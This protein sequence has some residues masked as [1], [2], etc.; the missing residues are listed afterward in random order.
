M[1]GLQKLKIYDA[2]AKQ[3]KVLF[4]AQFN[5]T[6]LDFTKNIT[7]NSSKAAGGDIQYLSF[8]QGDGM[9]FSC[10]LFLDTTSDP[11]KNI[12]TE[13]VVDLK[14]LAT[15]N[16]DKHRPPQLYIVWGRTLMKCVLTS[17]KYNFT[18]FNKAGLAIRGIAD[19]SFKQV[20][21]CGK[22]VSNGEQQ[23]PDHTKVR[24]L[25]E[26]DSLQSLAYNEYEDVR[27]WK[28]LAEHNNIE[29]PLNIPAGTIIEIPALES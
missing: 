12:Y 7:W 15:I 22:E 27:M 28:I 23:S 16:V 14:K 18:M 11:A 9:E 10:K 1:S 24:V 2:D 5:P 19:L 8:S 26:G 4:E 17:I 21:E 3:K 25:R 6:E 20:S 29:N 13:Y